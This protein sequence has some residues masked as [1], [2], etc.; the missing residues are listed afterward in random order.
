MP[1]HSFIFPETAVLTQIPQLTEAVVGEAA[2]D[3]TYYDV[4]RTG[5]DSPAG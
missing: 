3:Q 2:E 1:Q 4:E 5:G